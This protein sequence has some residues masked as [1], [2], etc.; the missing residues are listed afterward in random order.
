VAVGDVI[1][2]FDPAGNGSSIVTHRVTE[3]T[4]E[5]GSLAFKTKGDANNAEDVSLVP[6]DNLVGVY[7]R[8]IPGAGNVAMFMQTTTGL[9]ICVVIPFLL[10]VSY[11][12]ARRRMYEKSRKEDTEALLAEL[13][14]LRAGKSPK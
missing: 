12:M 14:E 6:A 4:T 11:D 9:I 3:I 10:L 13:A 7:Q 5:N 1:A 8:R 2:F